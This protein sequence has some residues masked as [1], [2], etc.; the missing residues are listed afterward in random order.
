MPLENSPITFKPTPFY[1]LTEYPLQSLLKRSDI[2]GRIAKW[3]TRLCSFDIRY[4]PKSLVKGQV[5]VNFI[6]KFS[7]RRDME[8]MCHVEVRPWKVFVN[9]ASNAMG[10][11]AG[12]I[13]ISLEGI[14]VKHSFR[15]VLKLPIMRPSKKPY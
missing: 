4:R 12:I 7:P 14:R 2:M 8:I 3:G 5:L 10:T 9:D 6:A 1:V 15:L 11:G 13:I